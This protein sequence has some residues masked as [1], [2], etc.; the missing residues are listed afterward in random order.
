M[1]KP[2]V[3]CFDATEITF[4]D[5]QDVNSA[6]SS[7]LCDYCTC[8]WIFTAKEKEDKVKI[9]VTA[10]KK[11]RFPEHRCQNK[12]RPYHGRTKYIKLKE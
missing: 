5:Q 12:L 11:Y 7:L 2:I 4:R 8:D 3:V 6:V 9:K 10:I 1:S